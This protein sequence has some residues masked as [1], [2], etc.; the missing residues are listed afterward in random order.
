MTSDVNGQL[1]SS[2]TFHLAHQ[3]A[4][5][6]FVMEVDV[7]PVVLGVVVNQLLFPEDLSQPIVTAVSLHPTTPFRVVLSLNLE[8]ADQLID[9]QLATGYDMLPDSSAN[10]AER[11]VRR[12]RYAQRWVEDTFQLSNIPRYLSDGFQVL[13]ASANSALGGSQKYRS[14]S[15]VGDA[16]GGSIVYIHP[17]QYAQIVDVLISG[18]TGNGGPALD[19]IPYSAALGSH[20]Y[21]VRAN[22]LWVRPNGYEGLTFSQIVEELLQS[23]GLSAVTEGFVPF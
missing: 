2:Y 21:I 7:L 16:G 20:A 10:A 4:G 9:E 19:V 6:S 14:F 3:D 15:V 8:A 1:L 12:L 13:P 5:G 22:P 17:S 11:Q 23:Q 18:A